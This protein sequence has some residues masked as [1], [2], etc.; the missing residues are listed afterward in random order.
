MEQSFIYASFLRS[1]LN[2]TRLEFNFPVEPL[3]TR[4]WRLNTQYFDNND[5]EIG[6][7]T[8]MGRLRDF[9]PTRYSVTWSTSGGWPPIA[10]RSSSTIST[11]C[12]THT[13]APSLWS[14]SLLQISSVNVISRTIR[15]VR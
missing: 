3:M 7:I 8:L 11:A 6:Q 4:L 13:L 9:H 2:L 14:R 5:S 1:R 12:N 10:S 15:A